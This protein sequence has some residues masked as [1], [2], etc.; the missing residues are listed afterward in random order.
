MRKLFTLFVA[1]A[2]SSGCTLGPCGPNFYNPFK[3]TAKPIS[4]GP[5]ASG[6]AA[7]DSEVHSAGGL[8]R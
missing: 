7:K 5:G 4:S 3:K 2:M 6:V 8:A 1:I